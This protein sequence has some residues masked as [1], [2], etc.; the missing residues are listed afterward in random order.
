MNCFLF[1]PDDDSQENIEEDDE[2]MEITED[3]EDDESVEADPG[4]LSFFI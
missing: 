4:S 3:N 1:I 2:G